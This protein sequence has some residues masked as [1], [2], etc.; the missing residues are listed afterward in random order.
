MS[1]DAADDPV[2]AHRARLAAYVRFAKRTGYGLFAYAMIAF[3][4]GAILGFANWL[5]TTIVL[6]MAV[7]SVLLA[8]AIVF[9]YGI[10]AAEREERGETRHG[11][12]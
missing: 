4:C 3:V 7:G 6:A 12:Y 8:P 10:R 2:L 11:G 9:G 5:I 1:A